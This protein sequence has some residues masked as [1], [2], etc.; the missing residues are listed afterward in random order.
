MS[1]IPGFV[2]PDWPVADNVRALVTTRR[3][4]VSKFPYAALNLAN[5]VGDKADLVEENRRRITEQF[6]LPS[7]P[8]W[9]QQVHGVQV[10]TLV[11]PLFNPIE[12]D[13]SIT[14]QQGLVCA[15]MTADCL[16]LLLSDRAGRK[17]AAIHAGWRG[18][19]A[20]I[21]EKTIQA[22]QLPVDQLLVWLGPAI[23]PRAFEVGA[24]VREAFVAQDPA[25][26]EAFVQRDE[27]HWLAD[28]YLLARQRLRRLGVEAVF[29]G[30][31]CTYEQEAL[32]YSYRRDGITGRMASLIWLD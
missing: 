31:F 5:H 6:K 9:L 13:A 14:A 22:M 4:G 26:E 7:P 19:C 25:A 28:I 32:F 8:A 30:D 27:S 2:V 20:G 11:E 23:G 29:G 18:L 24:D 1:D 3:G 10:H 16:P 21:I 15:V 17:V 12:A